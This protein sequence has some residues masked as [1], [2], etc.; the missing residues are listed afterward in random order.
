MS[1]Q[2]EKE[3]FRLLIEGNDEGLHQKYLEI[4]PP[5]AKT[6]KARARVI[7]PPPVIVN[8]FTLLDMLKARHSKPKAI[9][10]TPHP[11]K[12]AVARHFAKAKGP[13]NRTIDPTERAK[14]LACK[15]GV[16]SKRR[17]CK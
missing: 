11:L 4:N 7:N 12:K 9:A 10:E 2:Q 13:S 8:D 16:G 6:T 3:L 15:L 14:A 5:D 17:A 1:P